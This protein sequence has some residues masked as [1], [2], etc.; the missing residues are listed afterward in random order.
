MIIRTIL[1]LGITFS[2]TLTLAQA[3]TEQFI[4]IGFYRATD[5]TTIGNVRKIDE[6]KNTLT[7][8]AVKGTSTFRITNETRI[9]LDRSSTGQTNLNGKV[10]DIKPGARVEVRPSKKRGTAR[11]V[12]VRVID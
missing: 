3:L 1:I 11:W 8:G 10:N 6:G 7:V 9:W 5:G 4:P 12:K 2:S